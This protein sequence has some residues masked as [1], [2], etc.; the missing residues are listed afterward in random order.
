M[1]KKFHYVLQNDISDCGP[2]CLATISRHYG[3]HIPLGEIKKLSNTN[4]EG[5]TLESLIITA[6]SMGFETR[7]VKGVAESLKEIPLPAIAH[8]TL[9]NGLLHY[10]V[11]FKVSNDELTIADPAEGIVK[12]KL[13]DFLKIWDGILLLILPSE[14]FKKIKKN[15]KKLFNF[16]WETL[17]PYKKLLGIIL[18]LSIFFNLLGLLGTFYYQYLIDFIVPKNKEYILHIVSIS[19]IFAYIIKTVL[20]YIRYNLILKLS[21]NIDIRLIT[22]YYTHVMHLPMSF[23]DNRRKG[24]IISRFLDTSKIRDTLSTVAITTII[25]SFLV[26]ISTILL[27][28]ISPMLFSIAMI[29]IPIYFVIIYFFRTPYENINTKEMESGANFNSYLVETLAGSSTIKSFVGEKEVST[30]TLEK[31][32][33]FINSYVKRGKIGNLQDS[34]KKCIDLVGSIVI[35]WIGAMQV[36]NGNLTLGQL[37]TFNA[38]LAYFLTPLENLINLQPMIQTALVATE[39]LQEILD[40]EKEIDEKEE[41]KI[42]IGQFQSDIVFKNLNFSYQRN[43]PILNNASFKIKKGQSVAFVGESGSGKTTIA[44][45]LMNFYTPTSGE[46]LLD[47]INLQ[48]ISKT[49]LRKIV[50]Y[51]NQESFFFKGS[52]YENLCFGLTEPP[53]LE[54]IEYVAQLIGAHDFINTLPLKYFTHLEERAENLSAGQKQKISLMH[55]ILKNPDILILDEVTSNLDFNSEK[56]IIDGLEKFKRNEKTIITIAHRLN[57]IMH[58]DCI[59]VIDK[60]VIIESGT[61]SELLLKNGLYTELWN[62]QFSSPVS[63]IK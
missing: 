20:S 28:I 34:I 6:N 27:Y 10:V 14:K 40:L 22:Q 61:H 50:S 43:N 19:I 48:D 59:Y 35:L 45:I 53:S 1:F 55:A 39:R 31:F 42:N 38:L 2:A 24:E 62:N 29:F 52:I 49:S 57:T 12:Y 46:I 17:I 36:M 13:I 21:K 58:Y 63:L 25:D 8:I 51:V 37:I 54:R 56:M 26:I 47:D 9:P 60:G 18:I 7:A 15:K 4:K 41:E 33:S 44:K 23:F 32:T 3:S 11:I 16:F 30:K 5:T